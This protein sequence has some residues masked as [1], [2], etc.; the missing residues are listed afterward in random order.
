L[1]NREKKRKRKEN[2]KLARGLISASGPLL[3]LPRGPSSFLHSLHAP[4]SQ[5]PPHADTWA[6]L[7]S[8]TTLLPTHHRPRTVTLVGG[9]YDSAVAR[10]LSPLPLSCGTQ[11]SD[12]SLSSNRFRVQLPL[13]DLRW[14]GLLRILVILEPGLVPPLYNPCRS[15]VDTPSRSELPLCRVYVQREIEKRDERA[16]PRIPAPVG[17]SSSEHGSGASALRVE[18]G[19]CVIGLGVPSTRE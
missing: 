11:E 9:A 17:A 14:R 8:G 3:L 15:S 13:R 4:P 12:S 6:L 1:K 5:T 7:A 10:T 16:P 18:C 2:R 19:C